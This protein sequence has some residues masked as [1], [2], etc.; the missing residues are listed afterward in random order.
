MLPPIPR[1]RKVEQ[2]VPCRLLRL[3]LLPEGEQGQVVPPSILHGQRDIAFRESSKFLFEALDELV[4]IPDKIDAS[5]ATRRRTTV[6]EKS[7]PAMR[8][9]TWIRMDCQSEVSP[10]STRRAKQTLEPVV[11]PHLGRLHPILASWNRSLVRDFL[12]LGRVI[13]DASVGSLSGHCREHQ[14][15]F[16]AYRLKRFPIEFERQLCS[17]THGRAR[18][19]SFFGISC[20]SS[21]SQEKTGLKGRHLHLEND[22]RDR[23]IASYAPSSGDT[24]AGRRPIHSVSWRITYFASPAFSDIGGVAGPH[25]RVQPR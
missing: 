5:R 6:N 14:Q 25:P 7:A 17:A 12:T 10:C 19:G 16:R 13:E 23:L 18:E 24:I 15:L 20:H 3:T 9:R 4:D 21:P 8:P 11:L 1:S 22:C 2:Q